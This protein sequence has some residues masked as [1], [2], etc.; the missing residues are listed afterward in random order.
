MN[1]NDQ[2]VIQKQ[3]INPNPVCAS[4]VW[5]IISLHLLLEI[6]MAVVSERLHRNI[7]RKRQDLMFLS[8]QCNYCVRWHKAIPTNSETAIRKTP[9]RL[10]LSLPIEVA[11][12]TDCS[13]RGKASRRRRSSRRYQRPTG[14][15]CRRHDVMLAMIATALSN[16]RY[17]DIDHFLINGLNHFQEE[18]LMKCPHWIQHRFDARVI[19]QIYLKVHW[20]RASSTTL[21]N[22]MDP[23]NPCIPRIIDLQIVPAFQPSK[24]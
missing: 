16:M 18:T 19:L 9:T 21:E 3:N 1:S 15:A 20:E 5:P 14:P 7:Y 6:E 2:L 24:I 22:W 11:S 12:L 23:N 8:T 17:F 4:L 13:G 10:S